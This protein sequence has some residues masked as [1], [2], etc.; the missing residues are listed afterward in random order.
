MPC[1]AGLNGVAGFE[2]I[3]AVIRVI[4]HQAFQ[5]LN[6]VL[7]GPGFMLP[8][9]KRPAAATAEQY[10]FTDQLCQRLAQ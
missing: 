3:E 10:A 2:N 9:D 5:R 8:A 1:G 7:F 4:R 6:D